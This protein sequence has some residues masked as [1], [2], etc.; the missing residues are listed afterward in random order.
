MGPLSGVH[1][2]LSNRCR[3]SAYWVQYNDYRAN[4]IFKFNS[5]KYKNS[6]NAVDILKE[7]EVKEE[8]VIVPEGEI[9]EII[10]D[11]VNYTVNGRDILKIFL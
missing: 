1:W 9:E 6:L 11:K 5:F 8:G 2:K 4:R 10:F 7:L 3:N